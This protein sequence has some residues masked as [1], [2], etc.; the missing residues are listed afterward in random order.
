MTRLLP[1][2][3]LA[4]GI[5]AG[6]PAL[7]CDT[8]VPVKG[9]E[10][11][12]SCSDERNPYCDSAHRAL[13]NY[14]K[15]VRGN[16]EKTAMNFFA[17]GSPWRMYDQEMRIVT[18]AEVAEHVQKSVDK[19]AKRVQLLSSWSGIAPAGGESLA[20]RVGALVKGA[21]VDGIDGFLWVT[22]SGAL[23]TTRQATTVHK[24]GPYNVLPE[25]PVMV[26]AIPGIL[27][28]LE[29]DF[30]REKNADGLMRD[31]AAY[32]IYQLCPAK[33]LR[34][35]ERAAGFG[36]LIAAYN[37]ALMRLERNNAVDKD[38]AIKLLSLAAMGADRKAQK[39]L[40]EIRP[41]K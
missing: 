31:G 19:G 13:L 10:P 27:L 40:D 11:L 2:L 28:P 41:S 26:S 3:L 21:P 29:R 20:Q 15:K 16:D 22:P 18:P 9:S 33:A 5:T 17:H 7:A 36:S 34:A 32:D 14:L 6:L 39:K 37:A 23:R 30:I 8:S 38:R 1:A 24:D 25:H 4:L 35:F 12:P